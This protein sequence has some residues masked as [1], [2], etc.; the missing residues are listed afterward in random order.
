MVLLGCGRS[1]VPAAA[2]TPVPEEQAQPAATSSAA[3]FIQPLDGAAERV[4][5]KRFGTYVTPQDSPVQP[6]RFSGYH[7]GVDYE[8]FPEEANVDVP[9]RAVC[10]GPLLS[11]RTASGYGG[12]AVQSCERRGDPVTVVYGHL[13]LSSITAKAGDRLATGDALGVLGTGGSAETGGE[14]K[15]LHLGIHRGAD[16]N[17]RGYVSADESLA[18][19]IDP[20]RLF[21]GSGY[22]S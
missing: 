12:V 4:T 2:P 7:T 9:V 18:E 13:R 10:A 8:T 19:W 3:A 6:E 1:D 17:V 14:R 22:G 16:A 21:D 15:H 20:L 11:V 5:K